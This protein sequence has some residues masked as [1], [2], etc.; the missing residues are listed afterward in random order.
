MTEGDSY[1]N[2]SALADR[3]Q[4]ALRNLPNV[5]LCDFTWRTGVM[6]GALR[7]KYGLALP[8]LFQVACAIENGAC[9]ITNDKAL[10]KIAEVPVLLLSDLQT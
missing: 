5:T 2:R 1:D 3:Y 4:N 8:E 6:A 10:K 7:A 9:L